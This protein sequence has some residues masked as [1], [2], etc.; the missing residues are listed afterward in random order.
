MSNDFVKEIK[1]AFDEM[2]AGFEDELTISKNVTVMNTDQVTMA[3]TNDTIWLP[4]PYIM[5]SEDGI[6]QTGNFDEVT[7]LSVPATISYQKSS[8][9]IMDALELRDALQEGRLFA[10][11]K[12]KLSSDVETVART[13]AS[14]GTLTVKRTTALSG[15]DDVAA[16]D[17]IMNQTGVPARQRYMGLSSASYNAMASNLQV[18]S[19]SFG[20]SK[21]D[22]AY[23]DAYVGPVSS[24]QTYKM[25]TA[26]RI[27]AAAGSGITINTLDAG[28]QYYTP[29]ATSTAGTGEGPANVDNRYQQVTVSSTTNVVAGDRFTIAD[30]Y[31]VHQINKQNQGFLKPFKVVSVDSATTMTISPPLITNQVSAPASEQYQNCTVTAKS[32]TAALVFLNTAA[33]DINPFWYK[34]SIRIL[35]GRY[36]V[37]TDTG[38]RVMSAS[39]KQGYTLVFSSQSA[40]DNLKTKYRVD[41][42]FGAV[43]LNPEHNGILIGGQ[44]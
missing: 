24:F 13:V 31:A 18:A 42:L 4:V 23:E 7:Q 20:N 43:N 26:N 35:P 3:R 2:V 22:R 39:T 5:T 9:W 11:A 12:E 28:A 17:T 34:D 8:P 37:Q 6:D 41:I 30:V 21:S 32:G 29:V 25:F 19:R 36:A 27:D 16:C 33:A 1:V 14:G 40:I 38:M 15:F 44:S 10:A